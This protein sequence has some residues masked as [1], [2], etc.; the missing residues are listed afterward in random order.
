MTE[1]GAVVI[2]GYANGVSAL[3]SLARAGVRTAVVLTKPYDVAHHSRY[4]HEHH[5]V[6]DLHRRPDGLLDLLQD[7]AAEWRG[8]ALIPTNDYALTALAQHRELL[9]RWY[10]L[11]VPEPEIVQQVVVKPNTYRLA[12]EVGV[13]VPRC[14]GPAS[15]ATAQRSDISYPVVVKP[16]VSASFWDHFGKKLFVARSPFELVGVVDQVERAGLAAEVFDLVPGPDHEFYN[17]TVYL[18]R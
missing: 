7:R 17:Y 14:Y 4:A 15:R 13:A 16:Q 8:W 11:S 2:G 10:P 12:R 1:P 9:S 6:L 18:D 5:R 3:R